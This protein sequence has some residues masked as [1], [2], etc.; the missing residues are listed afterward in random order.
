MVQ[1]RI[2]VFS[3]LRRG[4]KPLRILNFIGF[5]YL[6]Y[7]LI[8]F[9]SVSFRIGQAFAALAI[10]LVYIVWLKHQRTVNLRLAGMDDIDAMEGAEFEHRMLLHFRKLGWKAKGTKGSGDFGADLILTRPDGLKIAAQCKRYTDPVGLD[11]IQQAVA[12]VR[13]YNADAAMVITNSH[14][15]QAA[16]ELA[17]VNDVEVWDRDELAKS[18]AG[19]A[20]LAG[21]ADL[22]SLADLADWRPS[23]WEKLKST[24]A[25]LFRRFTL[26]K[27]FRKRSRW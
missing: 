9:V 26:A 15:T 1:L 17:R 18:L 5:A 3:W 22:A 4:P 10:Y 21:P 7:W 2:N 8:H 14:L 20:D 27:V 23:P 25:N 11:A 16:K 13:Y 12:A 6:L 24:L 19:L